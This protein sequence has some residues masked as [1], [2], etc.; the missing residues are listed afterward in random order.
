MVGKH[1]TE[2]PVVVFNQMPD[3]LNASCIELSLGSLPLVVVEAYHSN[4]E[5]RGDLS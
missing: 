3:V 1:S 4:R 5:D 2:E